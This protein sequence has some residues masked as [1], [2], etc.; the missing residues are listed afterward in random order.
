MISTDTR[1]CTRWI[2]ILLA[3]S[4]LFT[5]L[6]AA[7]Q[8]EPPATPPE[9]PVGEDSEEE[10]DDDSVIIDLTGLKNAVEDLV[11]ILRN[12]TE[13][14]DTTLRELLTA[15][16]FYP[17]YVMAQQ[18]LT[19][20]SVVLMNT[21]SVH[22]NPVVEEVHRQVL[23][24]TYLLSGTA[25]LWTGILYIVG[26][27]I[28]VSYQQVRKVLPRIIA[29]AAFG[30]VSLPLLQLGVDLSDGLVLAFAP[31][32]VLMSMQQLA[33]LSV[34]LVLV[35]ILQAGLLLVVVIMFII[36]DVYLLFVAAISPILALCW[37]VP[38]TK[39]YA[40][41]FIAGWFTALAMAPLDMLVL[42]FNMA[43]MN[44]AGATALQSLSNW[45]LGVAGFV[46]MIWMPLQLYGASQAAVGQAYKLAGGAKQRVKQYRTWKYRK[47][48]LESNREKQKFYSRINQRMREREK[49][50]S[51]A[52]SNRFDDDEVEEEG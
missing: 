37:S 34:Q 29:A 13:M 46:L 15:L 14:W 43:M 16:L 19:M 31:K 33:G 4:F 27:V 41:T 24:I 7:V 40:D 42:R 17:F 48:N 11:K 23:I 38:Q 25:L 32:G 3:V 10:D 50:R 51:K 2:I 8:P 45:V 6:G 5:G 12:F 20:V 47:E 35:W 36:R 26:P 28:G 52:R 30:T 49:K 44:G 18:L 22:P 39:R 9:D 1:T 21:P